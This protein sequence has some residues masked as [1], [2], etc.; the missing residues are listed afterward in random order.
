[1]LPGVLSDDRAQLFAQ[2]IEREEELAVLDRTSTADQEKPFLLTLALEREDD[3]L[4]ELGE[5]SFGGQTLGE[6]LGLQYDRQSGLYRSPDRAPLDLEIDAGG[7]FRV[8]ALACSELERGA[9]VTLEEDGDETGVQGGGDTLAGELER[10][11]GCLSGQDG[12]LEEFRDLLDA[13]DRP[14]IGSRPASHPAEPGKEGVS[15][16]GAAVLAPDARLLRAGGRRRIVRS[17]GIRK[18]CR[19]GID[20]WL[21]MRIGMR[22]LTRGDDT[23]EFEE[24]PPS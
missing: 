19:A 3:E 16:R 5:S 6:L 9:A 4:T 11:G 12:G 8:R 14:G 21:K 2:T 20:H 1:V 22:P 17:V 24:R 18:W 13:L 23:D 7:E 10:G 15:E